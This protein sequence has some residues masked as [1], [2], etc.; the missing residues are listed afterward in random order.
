MLNIKLPKSLNVIWGGG[1]G[2]GRGGR[3]GGLKLLMKIKYGPKTLF[4]IPHKDPLK[5][6]FINCKE[7][8]PR[9]EL[10]EIKDSR[11]NVLCFYFS[12]CP[13]SDREIPGISFA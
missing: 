3:G 6:H 10:G 2:G 4:N 1:E 12:N 5:L 9:T 8:P 11:E 13:L 7:A